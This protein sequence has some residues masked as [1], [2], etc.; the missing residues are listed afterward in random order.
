MDSVYEILQSGQNGIN[1]FLSNEFV[2]FYGSML[3]KVYA[4][5]V[6]C[7]EEH[8]CM[9]IFQRSTLPYLGAY[10]YRVPIH[11]GPI[12][13]YIEPYLQGRHIEGLYIM[14]YIMQFI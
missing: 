4:W 11:R 3:E 10:V 8:V 6:E 1:D 5:P 2:I 9:H 7:V 12:Y 13:I 14:P